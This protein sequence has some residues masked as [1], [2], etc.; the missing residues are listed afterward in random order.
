MECV[1]NDTPWFSHYCRNKSMTISILSQTVFGSGCVQF[2][3]HSMFWC[4]S[5]TN[6]ECIWGNECLVPPLAPSMCS[7]SKWL[8]KLNANWKIVEL[9]LI[10]ITCWLDAGGGGTLSI[11]TMRI[12]T[13]GQKSAHIAVSS[14]EWVVWFS[15]S[16]DKQ[17]IWIAQFGRGQSDQRMHFSILNGKFNNEKDLFAHAKHC[18]Q[19]KG[20]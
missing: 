14:V 10:A 1:L 5:S 17:I 19:M 16:K 11:S 15:Q 20:K 7:P 12:L 3:H 18:I 8:S 6:W 9:E 4:V 13:N 2:P